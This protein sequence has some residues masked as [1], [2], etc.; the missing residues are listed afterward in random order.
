MD[1]AT[2][3]QLI[4][5]YDGVVRDSQHSTDELTV[6]SID[7]EIMAAVK[8][9]SNPINLSL[10]CDYNLAKLLREQYESVQ[11]GQGLNKRRFITILVTGQLSDQEIRDQIRHAYEETNRLVH[12]QHPAQP[13]SHD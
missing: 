1:E 12:R 3:C 6:Y 13:F 9:G 4:T 2:I 7:G 5:S 10:R 8:P 11:E